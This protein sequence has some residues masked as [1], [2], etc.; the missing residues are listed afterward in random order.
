M[1]KFNKLYESIINEG[2]GKPD[3]D[4]VEELD[5]W[6]GGYEYNEPETYQEIM[7]LIWDK[8]KFDATDREGLRDGIMGMSKK[9]FN[10]F[11]K[12]IDF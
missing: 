5:M 11:L 10:K 1:D 12:D 7:D 4:W 9:E 8:Y 6:L 2:Y 3:E